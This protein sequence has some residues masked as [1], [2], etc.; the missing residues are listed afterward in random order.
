MYDLEKHSEPGI[1]NHPIGLPVHVTTSTIPNEQGDEVVA[2]IRIGVVERCTGGGLRIPVKR[3]D[4]AIRH[5]F[6]IGDFV[7]RDAEETFLNSQIHLMQSARV[8]LCDFP[9][10]LLLVGRINSTAILRHDLRIQTEL[11]HVSRFEDDITRLRRCNSRIDILLGQRNGC[12]IGTNCNVIDLNFSQQS[13]VRT[14]GRIHV[15]LVDRLNAGP[16]GI[17]GQGRIGPPHAHGIA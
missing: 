3:N 11:D 5:G 6:V 16:I 10:E 12:I 9:G 15:Q 4:G 14:H 1:Q 17:N 2:A 7:V 8:G 13:A